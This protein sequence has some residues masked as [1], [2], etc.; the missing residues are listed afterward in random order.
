MTDNRADIRW[1]FLARLV[2]EQRLA[3][4]GDLGNGAFE[5]KRLGQYNLEDLQHKSGPTQNWPRGSGDLPFG[6]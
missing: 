6:H 4:V 2:N 1:H 5:I 3:D